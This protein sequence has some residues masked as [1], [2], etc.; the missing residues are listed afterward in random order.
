[1]NF[2]REET[3]PDYVKFY[4]IELLVE[5]ALKIPE[6]KNEFAALIEDIIPTGKTYMIRVKA[7]NY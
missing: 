3:I 7:K 5:I 4:S 6:L 2:L 1:M